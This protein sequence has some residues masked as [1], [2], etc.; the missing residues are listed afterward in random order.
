[1]TEFI[2]TCDSVNFDK[3]TKRPNVC[4][5]FLKNGLKFYSTNFNH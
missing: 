5:L 2:A 1:M 3:I 4:E